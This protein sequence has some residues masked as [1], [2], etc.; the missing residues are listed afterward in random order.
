MRS[1]PFHSSIRLPSQPDRLRLQHS[2]VSAI[3]LGGNNFGGRTDEKTSLAVL[4]HAFDLGINF[5]DTSPAYGLGRSEEAIGKAGKGR[6][7]DI[8]ITTKFGSNS[9]YRPDRQRGSRM[10]ILE[11]IEDSLN[12]LGTEYIDVL[13][14]HNPVPE[15]PILETLRTLDNLIRVGKVRYIGCSNFAGWQVCE[16]LWMSKAHR[17]ESFIAAGGRYNILERHLERELIPCCE[18]YGVGVGV[19]PTA[20]LAGGFLTGKYRRGQ[21]SSKATRRLSHEERRGNLALT[22]SM[23]TRDMGDAL[24]DANFEKL[25]KLEAF[26]QERGHSTGELAIAWLLAQSWVGTVIAGAMTTEQVTLNVPS[27]QWKLT[28]EEGMCA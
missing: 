21:P 6:R 10:Y 24:T 2:K 8:I 17:L 1:A 20:P 18:T 28:P 22:P 14:M 3:G 27:V 11:S 4:R 19:V 13:Y 23:R 7:S 16:A 25:E 5:V 15:T 26:A 12:R 9:N